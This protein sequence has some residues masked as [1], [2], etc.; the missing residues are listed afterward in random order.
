M[1]KIVEEF[2]AHIMQNGKRTNTV[3]SYVGNIV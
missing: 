3:Q 2:R 1:I